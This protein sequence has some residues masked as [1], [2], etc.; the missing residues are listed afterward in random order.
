[1]H[2]PDQ[3]ET[4]LELS[5][6]DRLTLSEYRNLGIRRNP[7]LVSTVGTLVHAA[8]DTPS[9]LHRRPLK[10]GVGAPVGVEGAPRVFVGD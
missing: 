6:T 1:M 5:V 8:H 7:D 3:K 10:I 2:R 9:S 4:V